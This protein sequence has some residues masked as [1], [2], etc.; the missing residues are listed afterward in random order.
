[1]TT[2]R[3]TEFSQ[4]IG[5]Y[6]RMA[7][8]APVSVTSHGEETVVLV[9]AEEFRRLKRRD[10]EVLLVKDLSAEEIQAIG[11]ARP[12]EHTKQFNDEIEG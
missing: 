7:Q 3:S 8:R 1:M 9:S 11:E 6:I 2:V 12:P 5:R 4:A 10:R